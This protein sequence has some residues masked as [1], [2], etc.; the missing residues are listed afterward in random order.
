MHSFHKFTLPLLAALS[1]AACASSASEDTTGDQSANAIATGEAVTLKCTVDPQRI[2][3]FEFN[4]FASFTLKLQ[5]ETASLGSIVYT[6]D[7]RTNVE[8]E[9]KDEQDFLDKG[10][11]FDGKPLSEKDRA[12][13]KALIDQLGK[14]LA[15]EHSLSFAGKIKRHVRKVKHPSTQYPLEVKTAGIDVDTIFDTLGNEG[16]GARLLLPPEMVE[17]ESRITGAGGKPDIEFDGNQGPLFDRY[18][19]ER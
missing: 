12:Q 3:R 13:A 4:R 9:R 5:G 10:L 11:D 2:G 16:T 6:D 15:A 17:D 1:V 7:Y 14:I 19:C 8:R 18:T